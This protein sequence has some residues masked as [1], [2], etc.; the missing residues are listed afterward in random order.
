MKILVV[1]GG[2][3]EH[4]IAWKIAQS[5]LVGEIL[6]APGNAGAG[7]IAR[8]VP[9]SAD[10]I[11]G[12]VALASEEACDMTVVGPELPLAM[13]LVD[14]LSEAGLAAFGPTAAAARIEGSKRFA[15]DLMLRAGIPTAAAWAT[16][17]RDEAIGRA[18]DVGYP[19]VVKADGLA[20]G[21]GVVVAADEEEAIHAIDDALVRRRFGSSGEEVL[22]EEHLEG[23]EASI[24]AFTDGRTAALL[25][26][27]QDHKRA[28]DGDRGPN[29]GG[30]GAYAPT[31]VIT[32]SMLGWIERE[33]IGRA[34][35]ALSRDHGAP[36]RGVLYAGLMVTEGG[37]KVIEFNCRFGDPEAQVVLPLMDGD[38]V[39][40]MREVVEGRLSASSFRTRPGAAACVVMASGGYPG[41]YEKGKPIAG[42]DAAAGKEGVTV[43]HA[44]TAR[45][46]AGVVT[47]GGRVLGVTGEGDDLPEALA[48]AYDGARAI[49]FDGAYYR[50]DIGHRALER[51]RS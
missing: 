17:S 38:I 35:E 19:V 12:L 51:A 49:R 7:E 42:L 33:I 8:A 28:L 31:P 16:S 2:G 32:A 30:M 1:G 39:E 18:R 50:T 9:V 5:P 23:E 15:K 46:D 43:F 44:G 13:G 20:A 34:I 21:K 26:P 27:S 24:L 14:R 40:V 6:V 45:G 36:Y 3:R 11:D 22:I 4:A 37:L 10:D 29:T 25:V 47:S 48:R 41:A